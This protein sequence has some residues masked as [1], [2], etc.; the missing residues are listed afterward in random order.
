M[1]LA[2]GGHGQIGGLAHVPAEVEHVVLVQLLIFLHGH[3][4][5]AGLDLLELGLRGQSESGQLRPR[6]RRRSLGLLGGLGRHGRYPAGPPG[7]GKPQR[8]EAAELHSPP[9]GVHALGRQA[10]LPPERRLTVAGVGA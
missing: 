6:R 2:L 9:T 1:L 7:G 4:R 8:P 10:G 3:G 5:L